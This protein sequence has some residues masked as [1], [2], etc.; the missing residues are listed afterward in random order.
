[1][2]KKFYLKFRN[3]KLAIFT[4]FGSSSRFEDNFSFLSISTFKNVEKPNVLRPI[5][6]I[7][8]I[9]WIKRVMSVIETL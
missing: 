6:N 3:Y 1:M 5:D 4:I 8:L 7:S 9:A 2:K